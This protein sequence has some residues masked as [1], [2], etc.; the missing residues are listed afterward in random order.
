MLDIEELRK[1]QDDDCCSITEYE[2]KKAN[3]YIEL[4]KKERENTNFPV[5]G[6]ILQYTD[7]YGTYYSLAHIE[8]V[9]K[10]SE[11]IDIC[12]SQSTIFIEK[13]KKGQICFS[14]SNVSWFYADDSKFKK[15]GTSKKFF[16]DLGYRFGCFRFLAD[17][18]V[19]EYSELPPNEPTTKTHHKYRVKELTAKN[20]GYKFLVVELGYI[21]M[22]FG[23][24][25]EYQKWKSTLVIDKIEKREHDNVVYIWAKK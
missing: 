21:P 7:E 20:N 11:E 4:L 23:T 10:T 18:N 17:V 12:E 22:E 9:F 8:K 1:M 15:V 25:E 3:E 5:A 24:D 16:Y 13:S 14:S 2:V 6:D 19:W